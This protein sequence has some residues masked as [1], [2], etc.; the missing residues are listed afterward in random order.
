MKGI[1]TKCGRAPK[2]PGQGQRFCVDCK[3]TA[4]WAAQRKRQARVVRDRKPCVLCGGIKEPG[5]GRDFCLKCKAARTPKRRCM[6]CPAQITP[7]RRKCDRCRAVAAE[8]KRESERLRHRRNRKLHPEW[9]VNEQRRAKRRKRYKRTAGQAAEDARMRHRLREERKGRLIPP[10]PVLPRN[11]RGAL[12]FPAAPLVPFMR[13]Y[14]AEHDITQ[15]GE[16]AHVRPQTLQEV[17][18]GQLTQLRDFQADRLCMA[19]GLQ[20]SNVYLAQTG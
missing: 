5:H 18:D 19:M 15:L 3:E 20:M 11:D 1:C 6:S 2:V 13:Q 14:V 8:A 10:V 17:L 12:R 9:Y 16:S 4:E 7:P